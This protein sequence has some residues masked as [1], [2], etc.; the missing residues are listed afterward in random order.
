MV[1]VTLVS[2]C[3]IYPM[4]QVLANTRS[5]YRHLLQKR[6]PQKQGDMFYA[7]T[8]MRTQIFARDSFIFDFERFVHAR[9]FP[10]IF[11]FFLESNFP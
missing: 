4:I 1:S 6:S 9:I 11:F 2:P 5:N 10:A 7:G 3:L 8:Q